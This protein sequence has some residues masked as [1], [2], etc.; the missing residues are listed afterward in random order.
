M[1]ST[2]RW[3]GVVKQDGLFE[4][5]WLSRVDYSKASD[6]DYLRD[7]ETANI[8][9][10]RSTSLLQ[11]GSLDYLGDNWLM[12]LRAQQF[13]SLADD[14]K[15][16]YEELPQFTNQYRSSG[17]PFTL[18]PILLAQYSN[19]GAQE[20]VVTGQRLYGEAGLD[21]PMLWRFGSLKPTLKYRQVSYALNDGTFFADN[22]LG[23]G[24]YFTD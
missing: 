7:L 15:K 12:N 20:D 17:T 8:D 11:L 10:Q 3:L 18:Q 9:A 4:E 13:Q 5:R 6:V 14:I 23:G 21:Y 24:Q 1:I 22:S 19:F 2:D 16:D